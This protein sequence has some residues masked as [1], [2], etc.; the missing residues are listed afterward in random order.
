MATFLNENFVPDNPL[1]KMMKPLPA[2]FN[3]G[4]AFAEYTDTLI[5]TF[6]NHGSSESVTRTRLPRYTGLSLDQHYTG[7]VLYAFFQLLMAMKS[8][9]L[10]LER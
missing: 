9:E 5:G 6:L 10:A 4:A 8:W 3:F 2:D 7:P 1:L